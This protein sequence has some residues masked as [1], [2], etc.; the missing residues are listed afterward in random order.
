MR[1]K[2]GG[3]FDKNSVREIQKAAKKLRSGETT[4]DELTKDME[5]YD[6]YLEAYTAV[7]GGMVGEFAL[8]EET[9]ETWHH[10]Y[11]LKAFPLLRQDLTTA[12][13]MTLVLPAVMV[14]EGPIW[15]TI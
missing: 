15:G 1:A 13:M 5:Y 4:V 14:I 9:E 10:Y 6:Y 12:T 7:L 3:K 8:S 2:T 11:G